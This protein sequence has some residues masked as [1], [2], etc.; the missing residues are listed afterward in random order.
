MQTP[1]KSLLPG[2]T[3]GVLGGGQLGRM[4]VHCAQRMGYKTVVLDPDTQSPAGLVSHHHIVKDYTDPTGLREL[5]HLCDAVTTEF[6][7]VPADALQELA[8][9]LPVNPSAFAVSIAQD[10]IKEK[11]HFTDCNVP[12]AP[13]AVI[14]SAEDLDSVKEHLLPGILKTA[15][16]G[17]D[18]KGQIRVKT[19]DELKL[20]WEELQSTNGG[21]IQKPM[22]CVLEKLLPLAFEC[23]VVLA[24]NERGE[25]AHLP[26]QRNIH[27]DGILALTQVHTGC[28]PIELERLATEHASAIATELKYVGVLCVEFFVIK[29][30]HPDPQ[31]QRGSARTTPSAAGYDLVVNEIAPRPHNS[32]HYS[33]EACDISQFE[34]QVRSLANLPLPR[35]R[36][37]CPALMLN[38]LGDLWLAPGSTPANPIWREPDWTSVLALTG[39]HLNL[40]GK[41]EPRA[42]RK[43]GHITI[44]SPDTTSLYETLDKITAI[45]GVPCFQR[46]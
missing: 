6:E 44:T 2:A 16:L 19:Q 43:M 38:L 21:S 5:L 14:S 25:I 13:Y 26:V 39:V 33:V 7:N 36:Q 31:M 15:R 10:R 18:G 46:P 35:P 29:Q 11:K 9:H 37:F 41:S 45:L 42:L 12:V 1:I 8:A 4:F 22:P 23:S 40:Y 34:L 24:R 17:Y 28:L 27:R 20:A 30:K 3:L 32:G